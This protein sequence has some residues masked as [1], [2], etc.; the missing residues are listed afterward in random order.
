MR[1]T[2]RS[3]LTGC[4]SKKTVIRP[5]A[6]SRAGASTTTTY[7]FLLPVS[8]WRRRPRGHRIAIA[9]PSRGFGFGDLAAGAWAC[10]GK[11]NEVAEPQR[12][13]AAHAVEDVVVGGD[14]HGEVGDDRVQD[15]KHLHHTVAHD[16]YRRA[17]A[18]RRPTD[19]EAGHGRV[20]VGHGPGLGLADRTDAAE[21]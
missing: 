11:S 14:D 9:M 3:W 5:G 2:T 4:R 15:Q 16:R 17:R 6:T 10:D 1:S 8:S 20:G 7:S 18:P 21:V 12:H 19:V 13:Q